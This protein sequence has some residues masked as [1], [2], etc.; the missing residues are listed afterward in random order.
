MRGRARGLEAAALVDGDIDDHA[1]RLHA[2][3]QRARHQPG[4][5]G[6][7]DQHA[8][9]HGL[10]VEHRLLD[11]GGRRMARGDAVA[12]QRI[13]LTQAVD[14]AVDDGHAR[15]QAHGHLHRMAAHDTGA[16]HHHMGRRHA[17]HA[18]Q[19]HAHA[20][21]FL[22]QV[23][24]R[25]LDAHAASHFAHRRQQRQPAARAGDGLVGHRHHARAQ[26]RRGLRRVGRQVQVGIEHL[27]R[28]QQ[29]TF[30]GLRLLDLDDQLGLAEHGGGIGH[31]G[32]AGGAVL[33]VVQA[34]G[35]AGA[36][37]H[38]HVMA[39]GH[40]FTHRGRRQ[41]DAV[42]VDLD[43][44]GHA[45]AHAGPPCKPRMVPAR[46]LESNVRTHGFA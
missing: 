45:D 24:G 27:A 31:Q 29:R 9:D 12:V 44:L 40:V 43:L 34:D 10:G 20:T 13:E 37:L 14:A 46:M 19:Q 3:H 38:P 33:R 28:P 23:G 16:Q 15:A 22:L 26:Q 32:G 18:A 8:A 21:A 39:M 1:A 11:R 41:A 25:G 35:S 5:R 4:R 36:G 7:G 6:A 42:F 17:G 2:R 30:G